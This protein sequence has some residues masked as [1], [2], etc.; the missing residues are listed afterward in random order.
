[1][2]ICGHRLGARHAGPHPSTPC[3][4]GSLEAEAVAEAGNQTGDGLGRP[5]SGAGP[6]GGGAAHAGESS[7]PV[8]PPRRFNAC[9]MRSGVIGIS[10]TRTPMA[11]ATALAMA[12]ATG[13]IAGSPMPL[14][15]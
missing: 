15:P 2:T 3:R 4:P 1:M 7:R 10:N 13:V 8:P 6:P 11:S 9:T 14:A 12:G 5:C